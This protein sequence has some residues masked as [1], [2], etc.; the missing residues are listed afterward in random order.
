MDFLS[1]KNN[2]LIK[3]HSVISRLWFLVQTVLWFQ[4]ESILNILQMEFYIG[5][6]PMI[7]TALDTRLTLK[8]NRH[9]LHQ[10]CVS[11]GKKLNTFNVNPSE[12]IFGPGGHL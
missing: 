9:V 6:Y 3:D 12:C 5:I 10:S 1:H 11:R 8:K 2:N 7:T 4:R